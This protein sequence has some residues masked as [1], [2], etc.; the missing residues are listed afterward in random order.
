MIKTFVSENALTDFQSQAIDTALILD[1]ASKSIETG[2]KI[3]LGVWKNNQPESGVSD[4][5]A[6][7][8]KDPNEEVW[9]NPRLD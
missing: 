3:K 9:S 4:K 6:G 5:S 2:E 7:R 1:A 8:I